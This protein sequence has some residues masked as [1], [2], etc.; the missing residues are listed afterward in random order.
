MDPEDNSGWAD[1]DDTIRH[2][3]INELTPDGC[4][5]EDEA[6]DTEA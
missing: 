5:P 2:Y 3:W 6:E 4:F 1:Q